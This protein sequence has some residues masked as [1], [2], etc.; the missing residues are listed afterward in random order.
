MNVALTRQFEGFIKRLVSTGRY[1]NADEVVRAGLRQLQKAEKEVFP[2]G[3]LQHLYTHAE[4][5][6]ETKLARKLRVPQPD[7]V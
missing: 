2:P 6:R 3:S 5:A 4:N 7:E 1:Q